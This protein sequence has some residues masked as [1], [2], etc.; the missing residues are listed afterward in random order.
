MKFVDRSGVLAKAR[1]FVSGLRNLGEDVSEP[2]KLAELFRDA[3]RKIAE[4]EA[5]SAPEGTEFEVVVS[6]A[7]ATVTLQHDFDSAVRWY[8]VDWKGGSAGPSLVRTTASTTKNLVLASYVAGTAIVRVEPSQY[9]L[10][11]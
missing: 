3:F 2:S 7:G 10:A 5:K 9:K 6:T 11:D 4:L 8:V 1:R